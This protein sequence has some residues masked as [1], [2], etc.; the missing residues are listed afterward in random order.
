MAAAA[1]SLLMPGAFVAGSGMRVD[2]LDEEGEQ[3]LREQLETTA[4]TR[5]IESMNSQ[6]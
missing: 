3:M 5:F 4:R 6:H 2:D 1:A